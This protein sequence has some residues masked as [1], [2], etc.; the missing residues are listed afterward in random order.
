MDT[1]IYLGLIAGMLTS[2]GFIPQII[3]GYQSKRMSDVSLTMPIIVGCGMSLWLIY[4]II[5]EDIPVM[6]ANT[7]GTIL[8]CTIVAMKLRYDRSLALNT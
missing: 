1:V 5:I 3:K 6:V 7:I 2:T 4:G 8:L